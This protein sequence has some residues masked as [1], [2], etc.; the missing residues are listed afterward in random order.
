CGGGMMPSCAPVSSITRISRTR[1]R[2]LTRTRSSRRGALV[3]AISPPTTKALGCRLSAF[4]PPRR[5]FRQ[6][7]TGTR[8]ASRGDFIESPRDEIGH[9]RRSF[10]AARPF[11]NR[12]R[13]LGRLAI[14]DD[15]H[16]GDFLQ[17]GF[18]NL[19]VYLFLTL[20]EI[21]AQTGLFQAI[22]HLPRVVEMPIGD[23]Q[24]RRLDRRQPQRKRP[25]VV[26]DEDAD[27][28]LEASD[29]RAMDDD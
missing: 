24:Y 19:V 25:R 5:Q 1:I 26:L 6:R 11:A 29:D 2:S 10:V 4:D 23:R 9:R 20:V 7:S 18:A 3:K 22:P 15:E 17:L 14:P 8:P 28:P 12:N 16:V 27:E 21:G 13:P